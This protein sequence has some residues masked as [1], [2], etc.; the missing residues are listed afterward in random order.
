MIFVS[1]GYFS[2]DEIKHIR[3]KYADSF[4]FYYDPRPEI[5]EE[6][7]NAFKDD[8]QVCIIPEAIS[9]QIGID[10]LYLDGTKSS[11][12]KIK[13]KE[14]IEV[15]ITS[16][17]AILK[18]LENQFGLCQDLLLYL[19]CEGEEVPIILY[20][21]IKILRQFKY[22]QIEFH[23]DL[24]SFSNIV[25]VVE[26]LSSCFTCTKHLT[27]QTKHPIYKFVRK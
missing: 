10:Y 27:S 16:I 25:H 22:I 8:L 19:N 12:I 4:V 5:F 6:Y 18:E 3:A 23:P 14:K 7:K 9:D 1:A 20:T 13:N 15:K 24:Y 26:K 11:L 21:P 2:I 17:E